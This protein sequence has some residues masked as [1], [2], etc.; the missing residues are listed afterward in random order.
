M[1]KHEN[2]QNLYK[3]YKGLEITKG[4]LVF[5]LIDEALEKIENLEKKIKTNFENILNQPNNI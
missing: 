1:T 4:E 3:K 2:F 5:H